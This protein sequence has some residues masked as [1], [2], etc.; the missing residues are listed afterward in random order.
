MPA[1]CCGGELRQPSGLWLW[2]RS[3]QPQLYHEVS[4][5]GVSRGQGRQSMRHPCSL[6]LFA[7]NI[8]FS[9]GMLE[10]SL[11]EPLHQMSSASETQVFRLGG[12]LFYP[13]NHLASLLWVFPARVQVPVAQCAKGC[14][15]QRPQLIVLVSSQLFEVGCEGNIQNINFGSWRG[16]S[17]I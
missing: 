1:L 6:A 16:N 4:S 7:F 3:G 5:C 12:K 9:L 15:T 10:D 17:V 14:S 8:I 2:A 11:C 13:L